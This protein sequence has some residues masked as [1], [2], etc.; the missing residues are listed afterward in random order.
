MEAMK[1]C[2]KMQMVLATLT[3]LYAIGG[4][5]GGSAPVELNWGYAALKTP[6]PINSTPAAAGRTI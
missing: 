3:M 1:N 4:V 6:R 5:Q 2:I